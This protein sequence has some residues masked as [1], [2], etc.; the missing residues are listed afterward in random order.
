MDLVRSLVLI[1]GVLT[2]AFIW[3]LGGPVFLLAF[4]VGLSLGL[5]FRPR[6]RT[7]PARTSPLV[8]PAMP[9]RPWQVQS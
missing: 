4:S 6:R 2:P 1:A 5:I 9:R 8:L 7:L 3:A